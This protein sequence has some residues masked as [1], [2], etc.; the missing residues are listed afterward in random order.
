MIDFHFTFKGNESFKKKFDDKF[1]QD[2]ETTMQMI[3]AFGY[4]VMLAFNL[5]KEDE[6][7]LI[8]FKCGVP[9][10]TLENKENKK[11]DN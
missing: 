2:K 9:D 10:P 4:L 5:K 1:A 3:G 7:S 11:V 8:G 6:V